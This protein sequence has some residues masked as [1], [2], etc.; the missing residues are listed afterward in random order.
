MLGCEGCGVPI[1]CGL[2]VGVLGVPIGVGTLE[3]SG[4]GGIV[5]VGVRKGVGAVGGVVVNVVVGICVVAGVGVAG[6]G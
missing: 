4:G 3:G 2:G 6:K 1:C 5:L